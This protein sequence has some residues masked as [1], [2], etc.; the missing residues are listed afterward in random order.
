LHSELCGPYQNGLSHNPERYAAK[1]VRVDTPYPGLY[2]GGS[3]LTV[4]NSFSG[5]T[6]AAWLVA[7]AVCGYNAVDHLFLEKN[8]TTDLKQFLVRPKLY[9]DGDDDVAVPVHQVVETQAAIAVEED[10]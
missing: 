3:D 1:G 2:A 7:N 4:G 5:S 6:V 10:E 9:N 8:I